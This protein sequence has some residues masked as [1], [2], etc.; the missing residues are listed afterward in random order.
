MSESMPTT[1]SVAV[2]TVP[3]LINRLF[4]ISRFCHEIIRLAKRKQN[5]D[6]KTMLKKTLPI[7][8]R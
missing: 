1:N 6:V 4:F 2:N 8:Q 5:K 7:G 3:E